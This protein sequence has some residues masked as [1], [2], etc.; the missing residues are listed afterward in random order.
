LV[1]SKSTNDIRKETKV[2]THDNILEDA[3]RI[4]HTY[5]N[6]FVEY[7]TLCQEYLKSSADDTARIEKEIDDV[8]EGIEL[9]HAE[10]YKLLRSIESHQTDAGKIVAQ[11][12]AA[13]SSEEIF[14]SNS[15]Y[16]RLFLSEFYNTYSAYVEKFRAQAEEKHQSSQND[17]SDLDEF[18]SSAHDFARRMYSLYSDESDAAT[19]A[20]EVKTKEPEEKTPIVNNAPVANIPT[21]NIQIPSRL[22]SLVTKACL[23]HEDDKQLNRLNDEEYHLNILQAC[24]DGLLEAGAS[25]EAVLAF[26]EAVSAAV[27]EELVKASLRKDLDYRLSKAALF[28]RTYSRSRYDVRS[29]L[30]E[31]PN[32]SFSASSEA[33]SSSEPSNTLKHGN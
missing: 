4:Y 5:K 20:T 9:I 26:N 10:I 28:A 19:E 12:R 30:T 3:M 22:K 6:S 31:Q 13:I 25:L 29:P 16:M 18:S 23:M 11:F 21:P 1:R 17:L 14:Y 15:Q 27:E 24:C 33:S 7:D 32:A 2:E 8:A